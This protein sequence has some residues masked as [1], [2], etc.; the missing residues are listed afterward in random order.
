[1]KL[2]IIEATAAGFEHHSITG[3]NRVN[4]QKTRRPEGILVTSAEFLP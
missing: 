2:Q 3:L 4:E 1:M